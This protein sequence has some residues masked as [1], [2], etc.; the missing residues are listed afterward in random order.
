MPCEQGVAIQSLMTLPVMWELWPPEVVFAD[1]P[2]GNY[3]RRSVESVTKCIQCGACESKC[4]YELPI[5][6]MIVE[7]VELFRAQAAEH[8]VH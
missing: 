2:I 7:H 4:P 5:R 1:T 6:E 8:G 3:A